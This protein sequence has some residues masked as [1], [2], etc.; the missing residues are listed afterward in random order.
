MRIAFIVSAPRALALTAGR[1]EINPGPEKPEDDPLFLNIG[2]T[3]GPEIHLHG[4]LVADPG[5]LESTLSVGWYLPGEENAEAARTVDLA[6]AGRYLTILE[7]APAE[8][9]WRWRYLLESR[10]PARETRFFEGGF[11]P[12]L[13]A[14]DLTLHLVHL[15]NFNYDGYILAGLDYLHRPASYIEAEW[16]PPILESS[17]LLEDD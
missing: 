8:P 6:G 3:R 10:R 2:R 9:G 17:G 4:P 12:P 11:Q 7:R 15:I 16:H 13:R 14:A 1:E 5:F